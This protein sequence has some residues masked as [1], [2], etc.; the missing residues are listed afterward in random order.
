MGT[1]RQTRHSWPWRVDWIHGARVRRGR[2]AWVSGDP[3]GL[4]QRR[5]GRL[6]SAAIRRAWVSG[7]PAGLSQRRAGGVISREQRR[8]L[9][10]TAG[11][12]ARGQRTRLPREPNHRNKTNLSKTKKTKRGEGAPPTV[13]SG[14]LS[15]CTQQGGYRNTQTSTLTQITVFNEDKAGQGKADRQETP[16]VTSRPDEILLKRQE[17]NT[18]GN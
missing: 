6:E 5:S 15:R 10:R 2:R 9:P 13:M 16:G 17:L 18:Q 4:S 7:D 11:M 3:A 8:H 14:L 12:R 1:T